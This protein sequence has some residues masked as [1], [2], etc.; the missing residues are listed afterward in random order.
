MGL[1]DDGTNALL[2]E[3][4][5]TLK[6]M[7]AGS[8]AKVHPL[9]AADRAL[10]QRLLPVID[11]CWGASVWTVA[12]LLDRA[13]EDDDVH[14]I[15]GDTNARKVGRLFARAQGVSLNNWRLERAQHVRDGWLWQVLRV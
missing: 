6:R 8:A 4:L 11:G 1:T 2:R 7:E 3:I 14:E 13:T 9:S 10:L 5:A 15:L 12:D